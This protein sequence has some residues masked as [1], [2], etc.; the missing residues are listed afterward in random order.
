MKKK[1]LFSKCMA[2]L[3]NIVILLL[4]I[5]AWDIMMLFILVGILPASLMGPMDWL[6][7]Y[8]LVASLIVTNPFIA[9]T[10]GQTF[11]AVSFGIKVVD[12]KGKQ[13]SR[14]QV[15]LRELVG[16]GLPIMALYYFTGYLGVA[17]YLIINFLVIM[18]DPY[19][20]SIIDFITHTKTI[21]YFEEKKSVKKSEEQPL[22]NEQEKQAE[23]IEE[24]PVEGLFK[25]D[26]HMHSKFS[27][28]GE[29]SVEELFAKAKR[30]GIQVMSITDHNCV[31]ANSEA[32]VLSERFGI[33]YI[34]G[35]EIDCMFEGKVMHLLGYG[36][37]YKDDRY[38]ELE[39]R[40]LIQER[41]ASFKRVEKI[42]EVT[43]LK[44][45]INSLLAATKTGIITG[46][47]IAEQLLNN[48]QYADEALLLPYRKNGSRSENP[49]VCFYWDYFAHGRPAY[50]DVEMPTLEEA[51]K[52]VNETGGIAVLA[53]PIK[54]FAQ[55]ILAIK[56]VLDA[57]VR[58]LE[59]FS[60]YHNDNDIAAYL[61][62]VRDQSCFVTCGSDFH[63]HTKPAIELGASGASERYEKL[64]S[65]FVSRFTN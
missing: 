55:D 21:S 39:N 8:L 65:V 7:K 63:G 42:Q 28:D 54:P 26:L 1:Y 15:M 25:Y 6:V 52:L 45:D 37:N 24:V 36:I 51:V 57:G 56:R 30:N 64:L 61:Q 12:L 44:V 48:P 53:H 62:I 19:G 9:L 27:D 11:G 5:L 38:I 49:F 40:H 31:K 2:Y 34:P 16:V 41:D 58:G 46:E 23:K 10:Y 14:M 22:L 20:R 13:A 60:S 33:S 29:Y 43:G 50:V 35:I 3:C 4:P 47:M 32:T 18:I 59:V 17:I